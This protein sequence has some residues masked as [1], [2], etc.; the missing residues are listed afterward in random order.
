VGKTWNEI[1]FAPKG[2]P[3]PN[4]PEAKMA[5]VKA[6]EFWWLWAMGRGT[7]ELSLLLMIIGGGLGW[8]IGL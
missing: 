1:F 5:L 6:I 4:L 2:V 8:F 3:I 7:P